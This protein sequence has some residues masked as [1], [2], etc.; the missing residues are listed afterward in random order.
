MIKLTRRDL[1]LGLGAAS[2]ASSAAGSVAKP[3]VP[4]AQRGRGRASFPSEFK[5]GCATAA[6]QIEGAVNDDGRGS[7]IWDVFTHTPGKIAHEASG[8]V[9][10]DSYH[11]F[12]EDTQLLK[13]LG[14][15][16]YRFSIAWPRI[17]P[18][19]RGQLNQKGLDHYDRVVDDLL[20]NGVE[21]YVTLFHWDLP[22]ALPG[23]WQSRAVPTF[24]P[25]HGCAVAE[26]RAGSLLLGTASHD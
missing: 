13:G 20:A 25:D 6:Y 26:G 3:R 14:A 17:F 4:C 2:V 10:C 22:N 8:D 21:P 24:L 1:A 19:G 11:R 23:G 16:A 18:E 12:R 15:N 5:W 7:S 9:A